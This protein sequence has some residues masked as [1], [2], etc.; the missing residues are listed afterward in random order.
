[1]A[2]KQAKFL[3]LLSP[4]LNVLDSML[5]AVFI[6]ASLRS[7]DE[8]SRSLGHISLFFLLLV[9]L[10]NLALCAFVA[11]RELRRP[12]GSF[13]R[14]F[15]KHTVFASFCILVGGFQSNGLLLTCCKVLPNATLFDAPWSPQAVELLKACCLVTLL[16][17]DL[18]QVAIQCA[19]LN[20]YS[21]QR[22]GEASKV[23]VPGCTCGGTQPV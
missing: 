20:L 10:S 6:Q 15:G 12:S 2:G 17:G 18:P 21:Q 13:S 11:A 4:C 23:S 9:Y 16:L 8:S 14:W 5:D 3:Y 19:Q 7:P 1:V 22:G